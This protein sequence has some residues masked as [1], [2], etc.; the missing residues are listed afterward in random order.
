RPCAGDDG[1]AQR[2]RSAS[3]G[4]NVPRV[5]DLS[6]VVADRAR[7]RF[8]AQRWK[9]PPRSSAA[10]V[11]VARHAAITADYPGEDVVQCDASAEVGALPG[12]IAQLDERSDGAS[13]N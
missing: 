2:R 8:V 3:H 1:G 4:G 7:E 6:V 9:D 13:A 12:A 5:I 10:Q 11:P